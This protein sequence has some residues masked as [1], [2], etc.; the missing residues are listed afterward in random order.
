MHEG[1][2][3]ELA[4]YRISK[5]KEKLNAAVIMKDNCMYED[6]FIISKEDVEKQINNAQLFITAIEN[7]I[8]V[9]FITK[10]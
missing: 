6:F 7:Y 1:T 8:E 4:I 2:S 3:L 10:Q 9:N 5:A